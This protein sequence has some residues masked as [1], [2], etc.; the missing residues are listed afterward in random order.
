MTCCIKHRAKQKKNPLKK[1]QKAIICA[2]QAPTS[3]FSDF[4][5][6]MHLKQ[7]LVSQSAQVPHQIQSEDQKNDK[8]V[9][10]RPNPS[11]LSGFK[12]TAITVISLSQFPVTAKCCLD[13]DTLFI[14]SRSSLKPLQPLQLN[15]TNQN[16]FNH[17]LSIYVGPKQTQCFSILF[18]SCS[19]LMPEL[20]IQVIHTVQYIIYCMLDDV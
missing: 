12:N 3:P 5:E 4:F 8:Q 19:V 6:F 20:T 13:Y 10:V 2:D 18:Y 14:T 9:I 11:S 15:A 17:T 7:S 16:P 1:T